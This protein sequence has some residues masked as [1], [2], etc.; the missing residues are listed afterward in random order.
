MHPFDRDI[1]VA[2]QS[3]NQFKGHV[4]PDWS[5]SGNPNGGYLMAMLVHAMLQQSEK[6]TLILATASYLARCV[7]GA[8]DMTIEPL[9][10]SKQFDRW[11]ARL[12]QDGKEKVRATGTF[13]GDHNDAAEKHY[14][15]QAPDVSPLEQC[16]KV[17]Q[18]PYYTFFDRMD[19]RLDPACAGWMKGQLIDRSEHRGWVKFD[20]DRP[21]DAISTVLMADSLPPPVLVS[22]GPVAWVPTLE[23]SVNIR[24]LPHSRWLRCKLRTRFI[25]D[26]ILEEDGEVW[27]ENGE[28]IAISRQIAQ[29]RKGK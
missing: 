18:I 17:P 10:S 3:P 5:L 14:E 4:S 25:T 13:T 7:P 12:I 27:D 9:A 1:V 16:V 28:L 24:S 21:H 2:R 26:G 8:A 19:I 22:H 6:K 29:F 23:M 20:A 15:A 11:E